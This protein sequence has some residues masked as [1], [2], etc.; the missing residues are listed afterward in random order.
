MI[1]KKQSHSVKAAWQEFTEFLASIYWP[2]AEED[3]PEETVIF[4][5]N[6]FL[7]QLAD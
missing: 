4:E 3:L 6:A 2:G 1:M 7:S 5:F